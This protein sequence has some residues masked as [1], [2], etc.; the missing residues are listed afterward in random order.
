MGI[1][2]LTKLLS[3]EA[4]DAVTEHELKNFNGRTIAIDASMAIYQFL[5]RGGAPRSGARGGSAET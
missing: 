1:K 4:P 2:G 3:D 5:V